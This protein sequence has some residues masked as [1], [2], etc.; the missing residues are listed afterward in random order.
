MDKILLF[1]P[2]RNSEKTIIRV[3]EKTKK[4][5]IPH[6]IL[7][8]DNNSEDRT[9]ELTHKYKL[10]NC[11][12]LR[13][14]KNIGY[15]ESQKT[16]FWYGIYNNYDYMIIIHSDDQ[17][18][19]ADAD[20]LYKTI[21]HTK[22]DMVV[23]SRTIH[24]DIKKNMPKWR[25]LG[26]NLLSIFERWA[27]NINLSEFHSEF[28]IYDLKFMSNIDINKWG[29]GKDLMMP[30][31][32]S[33]IKN[34]AKIQEIPILCSYHKDAQHPTIFGLIGYIL[35]TLYGGLKYKLF[36]KTQKK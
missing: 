6:D 10:K 27:L 28:K 15:F 4:L 14:V 1:I 17:Y 5:N 11:I 2:C 19:V 32:I 20:R 16:A 23:G 31:L 3:L 22:A 12:I 29:N 7:V 30:I 26:N 9:I 24:K 34:K 25:F 35:H 18:P 36:R 13:N 8:V 21:K 33:L